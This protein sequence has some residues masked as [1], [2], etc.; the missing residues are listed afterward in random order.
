ML[1]IAKTKDR[2]YS[3]NLLKKEKEIDI[4]GENKT[5]QM[6]TNFKSNFFIKL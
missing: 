2:F 5:M 6:G 4:F 1:Y 3:F